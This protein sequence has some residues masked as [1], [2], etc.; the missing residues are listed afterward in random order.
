MSRSTRAG[1]KRAHDETVA[2][3]DD[4]QID[5]TKKMCATNEKWVYSGGETLIWKLPDVLLVCTFFTNC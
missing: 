4:Q 2:S 1:V 5:V 3:A